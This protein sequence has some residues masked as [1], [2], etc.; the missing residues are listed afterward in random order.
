MSAA[1][2]VVAATR[3]YMEMVSCTALSGGKKA[4]GVKGFGNMSDAGNWDCGV[5]PMMKW[6][7]NKD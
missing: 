3:T 2:T 1:L 6:S 4:I 5:A 7:E